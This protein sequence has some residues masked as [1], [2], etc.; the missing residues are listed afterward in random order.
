MAYNDSIFG[1]EKVY[2]VDKMCAKAQQLTMKDNFDGTNLPFQQG[3]LHRAQEHPCGMRVQ[4]GR[5][6]GLHY[7][8]FV[9]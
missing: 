3:E 5:K 7:C 9:T 1:R 2:Y 8:V 6:A 4:S